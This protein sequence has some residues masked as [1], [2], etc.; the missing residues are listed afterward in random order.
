MILNF[1]RMESFFLGQDEKGKYVEG[2][3]AETPCFSLDKSIF[4]DIIRG[5]KAYWGK[6]CASLYQTF[7]MMSIKHKGLTLQ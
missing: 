1:L 6:D 7:W 2:T 4:Y 5:D 3:T